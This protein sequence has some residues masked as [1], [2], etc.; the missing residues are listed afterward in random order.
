MFILKNTTLKN[1]ATGWES[2]SDAIAWG[3]NNNFC[4]RRIYP[5]FRIV[6]RL[7]RHMKCRATGLYLILLSFFQDTICIMSSKSVGNV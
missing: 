4:S 3:S 7:Q 6:R 2:A 1:G 5:A